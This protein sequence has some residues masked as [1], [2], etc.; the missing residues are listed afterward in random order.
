MKNIDWHA[1]ASFTVFL[2]LMIILGY[3]P[4]IGVK[5]I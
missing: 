4:P 1:V 5:G 2:L 3:Q